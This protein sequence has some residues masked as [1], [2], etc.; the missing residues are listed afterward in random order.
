LIV[1]STLWTV[2]RP[3]GDSGRQRADEVDG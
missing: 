1:A 3:I 2:P